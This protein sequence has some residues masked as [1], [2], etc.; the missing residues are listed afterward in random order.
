MDDADRAAEYQQAEIER[1]LRN[2]VQERMP[3]TGKCYWCDAP[4]EGMRRFCDSDCR[5]DHHKSRRAGN[6]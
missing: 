6:V 4:V 1:A 3:Y 2:V 5:D